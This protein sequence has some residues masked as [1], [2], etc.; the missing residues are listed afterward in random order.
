MQNGEIGCRRIGGSLP[1]ELHRCLEP[2]AVLDQ[3]LRDAGLMAFLGAERPSGQH[4]VLH[5]R[6]ADQAR[7]PDRAAA[8]Q[9]NA[10][11]PLRQAVIGRAFGDADMGRRGK[12]QPA[13][14]DGAVQRRDDRR[15]PELDRFEGAMPHA[16]M[17]DAFERIM[18]PRHFRKIEPGREMRALAGQH[19]R[20]NVLR[21]AGE[22]RLEPQHRRVVERVALLRARE[23]QMRDSAAPRRLEGL[24]Q[25][26]PDRL[27]CI[28]DRQVFPPQTSVPSPDRQLL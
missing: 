19:D 14:D 11:L 17:E 24:R 15:A 21:Q 23:A 16:R 18:L 5:P 4:H 12:L 10:A 20:A 1:G 28:I 13:A 8:A 22:E 27:A 6:H 9:E 25:V 3:I 7:D 2:L 26:D